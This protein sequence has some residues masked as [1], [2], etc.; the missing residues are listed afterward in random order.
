VSLDGGEPTLLTP[1]SAN[2]E[3]ELSPD[4]HWIVDT[5]STPTRAPVSVV[6]DARSG[7]VVA[8]LEH[9]DLSR[10]RAAGWQ[11]PIPFTVK[12][13]DGVTDLYGLMFR[14]TRFDPGLK[15]PVVNYIYPGPQQGSVGS[16]SFAAARRDHQA[17]AE[18]GFIVVALDAMGTPLRSRTFRRWVR[19]GR[20]DPPLP[21]ILQ[22]RGERGR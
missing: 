13:R 6:R 5:G 11:P 14:P 2:H 21:R 18:L 4:G 7:Q 9:G 19:G 8:A 20:G 3:V 1:D 15:Y 16:R 17:L 12:A 22:G 10:L